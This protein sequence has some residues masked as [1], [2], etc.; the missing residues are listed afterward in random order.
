ME[1]IVYQLYHRISEILSNCN[2][3]RFTLSNTS[4]SALEKEDIF[5]PGWSVEG[6]IA[7]YRGDLSSLRTINPFHSTSSGEGNHFPTN[8]DLKKW[9]FL[10]SEKPCERL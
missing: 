8:L 3:S 5:L 6:F 7:Q 2:T 10:S 9:C 4:I 1:K